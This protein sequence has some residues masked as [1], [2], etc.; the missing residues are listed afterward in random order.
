MSVMVALPK[1]SMAPVPFDAWNAFCL[2]SRAD[3]VMAITKFA[4]DK[5]VI[6]IT[7]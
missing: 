5:I 2:R 4:I 3:A 6:V 1:M 7:A